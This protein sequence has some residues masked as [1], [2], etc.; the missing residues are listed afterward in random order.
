M[1]EKQ[2]EQLKISEMN[3]L[4]QF[5]ANLNLD[6]LNIFSEN[7]YRFYR[8][9]EEETFLFDKKTTWERLEDYLYNKI[10]IGLD[11]HINMNN[12]DMG[13]KY[14]KFSKGNIDEEIEKETFETNFVR[15]TIPVIFNKSDFEDIDQMCISTQRYRRYEFEALGHKAELY[16]N[17]F[18]NHGYKFMIDMN[19]WLIAIYRNAIDKIIEISKNTEDQE[20]SLKK[21]DELLS[22]IKNKVLKEYE[23]LYNR[24]VNGIYKDIVKRLNEKDDIVKKQSEKPVT[25]KVVKNP[26][27]KCKKRKKY[28]D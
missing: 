19:I 25:I 26:F 9:I 28:Y 15:S 17:T 8:L 6:L 10:D 22:D 18:K 23:V 20:E 2:L 13:F 12:R 7:I 16:S 11:V 5:L 27:L 1:K 24:L 3:Q 21:V 14:Y 4:Y